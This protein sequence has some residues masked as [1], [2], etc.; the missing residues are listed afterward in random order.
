MKMLGYIPRVDR[1]ERL[2]AMLERSGPYADAPKFDGRRKFN[3]STWGR[4]SRSSG[5]CQ[6]SAC[7]LGWASL[8]PWFNEQGLYGEWRYGGLG[9]RILARGATDLSGQG[10]SAIAAARAFFGIPAEVAHAFFTPLA[11]QTPEAVAGT[12]R[13]WLD[14]NRL[15]IQ[16]EMIS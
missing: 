14:E 9:R 2:A 11:G 7:A 6:T 16:L 5:D 13:R 8:D 4:R 15:A 3:M 1:L 10:G 12:I